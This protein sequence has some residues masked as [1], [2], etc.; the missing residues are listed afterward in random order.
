MMCSARANS[1]LSNSN[2]FGAFAFFRLVILLTHIQVPQTEVRQGTVGAT[3]DP[4]LVRKE[5]NGG[6]IFD[7]VEA[8]KLGT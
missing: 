5:V 6:L 8:R 1:L 3:R 4:T 7:Y 2:I